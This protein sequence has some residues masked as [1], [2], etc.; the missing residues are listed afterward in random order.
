MRAEWLAARAALV[1]AFVLS[2]PATS[3]AAT[4]EVHV[5]DFDFSVNPAGQP[6]VDPRI[7]RGDTVR[8][9]FDQGFHSSTSVRN[10]AEQ[11]DSGVVSPGTTFS[12]TFTNVGVFQYYCLPH[13]F[14]AGN[15]TAGG[16]AGRIT[17]VP[18]PAG[19]VGLMIAGV[20]VLRR[21]R[22]AA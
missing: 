21:R 6:V 4:I 7:N 3:R 22:T 10:I 15:G 1:L 16:M 11:W 9:R 13:G 19:F 2:V 5:F 8:W 14:D 12:H 20:A 18:E 17:V